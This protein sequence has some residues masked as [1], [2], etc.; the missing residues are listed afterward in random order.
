MKRL[1]ALL[2][3]LVLF[4]LPTH[5]AHASCSQTTL[6]NAAITFFHNYYL[7]LGVP[8][9]YCSNGAC[10]TSDQVWCQTGSAPYYW[11]L[12]GSPNCGDVNDR[13]FQV[14]IHPTTWQYSGA[15]FK[16]SCNGSCS[17]Q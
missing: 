8:N 17:W 13:D 12:K 7:S 1:F 9:V 16:C 14:W 2:A 4:T 3:L 11:D 15:H 5:Q 6:Q 10:S